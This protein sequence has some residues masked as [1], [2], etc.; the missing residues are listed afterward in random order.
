MRKPQYIYLLTDANGTYKAFGSV[1]AIAA[2]LDI[3][4][5]TA[6]TIANDPKDKLI[7]KVNYIF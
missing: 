1:R 6:V 5:S 4:V 7:I 3:S 2:Y